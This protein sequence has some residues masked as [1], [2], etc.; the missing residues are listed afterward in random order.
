MNKQNK[1]RQAMDKTLPGLEKDVW[2]DHRVLSRI[3]EEAAPRRGVS[4]RAV[5]AVLIA[6]M[7]LLSAT[8]VAAVLLGGR[9]VVDEYAVPM[10][11]ENDSESYIKGY[12]THKELAELLHTLNENGITLEEQDTIMQAFQSGRGFWEEDVIEAICTEAFGARM[13][14]WSVA[15]KYWYDELLVK[16]GAKERNWYA[17]PEESDMTVDAARAHASS[18]LNKEYSLSLP[19][20]SNEVWLICEYFFAEDDINPAMWYFNF[21]NRADSSAEYG[22]HF[23]R[24]GKVIRM[25]DVGAIYAA[26]EQS[27]VSQEPAERNP[28]QDTEY[29]CRQ[30][31]YKQHQQT[32]GENWWFWPLEAQ[33]EAIGGHH[34]VPEGDEMSRDEAVEIALNAIR[35]QRGEGALDALG[36][37]HIG[38]IC[39]RYQEPEGMW[40]TWCIYVTSDPV[41]MSDGFR[42]DLDDP[43]GIQK[44]PGIEV[45]QANAGNG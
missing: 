28:E 7:L 23:D 21:V 17:L 35:Q 24:E 14:A 13:Y 18:L 41:Y 26:W 34:H 43:I 10:A 29:R 19:T 6:A 3:H 27:I 9:E 31:A 32:Y 12:Y 11:L 44:M 16:I 2:F 8:A 20:E 39:Q 37:Y 38:A 30:D 42:V 36:E 5:L 22:V 33:Q 40:I 4:K 25:E 1:L 15:E 45:Q